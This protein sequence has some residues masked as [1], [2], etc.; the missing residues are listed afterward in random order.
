MTTPGRGGAL[1]PGSAGYRALKIAV[2]VMG[3]MIVAGTVL[4]GVLA[5]RRLGG[6]VAGGEATGTL[7][8]DEP[9]GTRIVAIASAGNRLAVHVTGGGPDRVLLVDPAQMTV[10]ARIGVP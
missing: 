5:T 9:A 4:L 8:L 3:L 6:A 10:T 1:A 7:V 2:V